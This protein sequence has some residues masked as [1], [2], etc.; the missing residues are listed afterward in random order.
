MCLR[1][2]K[3]L[4][5]W[6]SHIKVLERSHIPVLRPRIK[7]FCTWQER[8]IS[9]TIPQDLCTMAAE[10]VLSPYSWYL[11]FILLFFPY[12]LPSHVFL[13]PFLHLPSFIPSPSFIA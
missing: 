6:A 13:I 4:L 9:A 1:V 10:I 3:S 5:L 12:R 2:V 7:V 11:S 8:L